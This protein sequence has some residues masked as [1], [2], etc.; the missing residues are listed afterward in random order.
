[1]GAVTKFGVMLLIALGLLVSFSSHAQAMMF[2]SDFS[3]NLYSVNTSTAALTLIGNTG[4]TDLGDITFGSNGTLYGLG[5]GGGPA[6]YT[7]NTTTATA[8]LVGSTGLSFMFEGGL[9][10]SPGGTLYGVSDGSAATPFL[11]TINPN[12]G[13]ATQVGQ[14]GTGNDFNGIMWRSDGMLVGIEDFSNSLKT[15]DP[16]TAAVANLAGLGFTAGAVGGMTADPL[17]GLDYFATGLTGTSSLY[18]FDPFLGTN[19]L[20]GAFG[21]LQDPTQ[22]GVSGIAATPSTVPE[23]GTLGLLGMGLVGLVLRRRRKG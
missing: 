7:I 23:P 15:I 12:T 2:A 4:I 1:M 19:S 20:V 22:N 5:V 6:L 13:V 9:A 8:T 21:G 16:T 17:S 3:G 10:F 18:T 14:M 11:E